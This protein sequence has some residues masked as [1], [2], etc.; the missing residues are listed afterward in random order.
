VINKRFIKPWV[1]DYDTKWP[2]EHVKICYSADQYFDDIIKGLCQLT[3][4]NYDEV[5]F[6]EKSNGYGTKYNCQNTLSN[7]CSR[8]NNLK[9]GQ[10]HE[11]TFFRI[12]GYKKGTMHFEFLDDKVLEQFNRRVAEIKGWR[13]PKSTKKAYR[14]KGEGITLFN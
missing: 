2:T 8:E 14:A 6:M 5:M 7:F 4:Q 1:T 10:W 3:G 12:R 13:L 11:W 9:W